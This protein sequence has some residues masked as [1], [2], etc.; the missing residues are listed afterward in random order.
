MQ[1]VII[2]NMPKV[3]L[4]IIDIDHTLV[5]AKDQLFYKQYKQAVNKSVAK[6]LEIDLKRGTGVAN[7]YREHFGGGEQ[8]LFSGTIGEYFPKYGD[9]SP[10]YQILYNQMIK[11]NPKGHF[12]KHSD[13]LDIIAKI[14]DRGITVVAATSTPDVLS[15]KILKECGFDPEKDFDMFV[16]Y[17]K[18]SGPPKMILK[19][20]LFKGVVDKFNTLPS[21]ALSIGDSYQYDIL[22]ALA[23]GMKTC[24]FSS[25]PPAQYN[26]DSCQDLVE[27]LTYI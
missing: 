20:K 21:D 2:N 19:E 13:E 1:E 22:P 16:A 11:I 26:G 8:A 25:E 18:E 9:R 12:Q 6:F 14:R 10:D 5:K 4:L 17:A 15:R 24:L 3:K 23:L 7:F 27:Y